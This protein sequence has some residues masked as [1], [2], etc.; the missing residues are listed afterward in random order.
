MLLDLC[1]TQL[2]VV[3]VDGKGAVDKKEEKYKEA[4]KRG[5]PLALWLTDLF[6]EQCYSWRSRIPSPL[7]GRQLAGC[8]AYM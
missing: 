3:I 2:L 6:A 1:I 8:G 4:L 7:L 5:C